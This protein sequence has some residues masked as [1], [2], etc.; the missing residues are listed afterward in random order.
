MNKGIPALLAVFGLGFAVIGHEDT[1]PVDPA[2]QT[3]FEFA[4]GAVSRRRM[5]P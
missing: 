5:G 1:L 2:T 3:E 4:P